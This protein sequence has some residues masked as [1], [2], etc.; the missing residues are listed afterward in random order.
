M[1]WTDPNFS[2]ATLAIE[3]GVPQHHLRYYF[4]QHLNISFSVYRNRMRVEHAKSLLQKA[5]AEQYSVEGIGT[6]AG[7]S[8]KSSFFSVFK[9]VTGLT[10]SEYQKNFQQKG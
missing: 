9:G 4:N 8:S 3:L 5:D 2:I 1:P 7:F 6:L 10:P